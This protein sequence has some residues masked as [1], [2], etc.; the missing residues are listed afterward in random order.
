[1]LTPPL[2]FGLMLTFRSCGWLL[3]SQRLNISGQRSTL[4]EKYAV[5]SWFVLLVYQYGFYLYRLVST[6]SRLVRIAERKLVEHPGLPRRGSYSLMTQQKTI[7]SIIILLQENASGFGR[8]RY[9]CGWTSWGHRVRDYF[10]WWRLSIEHCT[11]LGRWSLPLWAYFNIRIVGSDSKTRRWWMFYLETVINEN[12]LVLDAL[13]N[14]TAWI[15][16]T[17]EARRFLVV[18]RNNNGNNSFFVDVIRLLEPSSASPGVQ[19]NFLFLR[20]DH[21]PK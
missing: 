15:P 20:S 14:F 3:A 13:R 9:S 8:G 18:G 6:I 2:G 17:T 1:M 21:Q 12:N 4:S 19:P 5:H 16:S 7:L 10:H 11:I